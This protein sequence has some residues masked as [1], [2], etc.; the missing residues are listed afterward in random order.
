[1]H[2][3]IIWRGIGPKP[4]HSRHLRAISLW[5]PFHMLFWLLL[6][7]AG[8]G[9][10]GRGRDKTTTIVDNIQLKMW[11]GTAAAAAA[12]FRA[13][14]TYANKWNIKILRL[15]HCLIY[16]LKIQIQLGCAHSMRRTAFG[17]GVG[18]TPS[19]FAL[20]RGETQISV[21]L[22]FVHIT[23]YNKHGKKEII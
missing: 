13:T 9:A 18:W 3:I 11:R 14:K 10:V 1:M 4:P 17:N 21:Y 5:M 19:R 22:S 23:E 6:H 20:F 12:A 7:G 15:R 16:R 2:A 8:A